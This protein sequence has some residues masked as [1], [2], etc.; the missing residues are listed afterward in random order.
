[1]SGVVLFVPG[2][3]GF[4]AFGHPDRPL[5]EYFAR[6]EDAVLK[7]HLRE[8]RFV[9]HEPP[10][11]GS[12]VERVRSLHLRAQQ[13]LLEGATELHLVGHSTGGLDARLLAHPGYRALPERAEL[14]KRIASVVTVSAPF[15]GT[16]LARRLG[17][18]AFIALPAIWFASI[19]ASRGRL[20]L[21]GHLAALYNFAKQAT[22]Q[23]VTPTE[24]LIANLA[25][26]DD[27]TAHQI[28]SFLKD[29]ARDHRLVDDLKPEAMAEL[30][31]ALEGND[32]VEPRSFVSVSP[33]P[34]VGLRA[35]LA[36]AGAPLQRLFYDTAY[37]MAAGQPPATARKPKGP[38]IGSS[39]IYVGDLS[40][41]GIVPAWSQTLRG[42]ARGV[43][44]GDHL[45]VI[46]HYEAQ[47]ATFLRSGSRF[48]DARFRALWRE[49][50]RALTPRGS[51]P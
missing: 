20:R 32:V 29:V 1:M 44:L 8:L 13:V 7:A 18:A 35:A 33:P 45:D 2:F 17:R 50:A 26:V 16:P 48:D 10:P 40:S 49:V 28:R 25:D 51:A 6:V 41:D 46:G 43:V 5:V 3:F 31:R 24:E 39:S 38:W 14:V 42:E 21:A 19:L 4:G 27:E 36:F 34:G 22:L 23:D 37:A 9:V 47:N 30:N 12:L 11:A 15:H